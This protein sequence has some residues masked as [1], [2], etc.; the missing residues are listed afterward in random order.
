MAAGMEVATRA[1]A[2]LAA[3]AAAG[4]VDAV[5]AAAETAGAADAVDAVVAVAGTVAGTVAGEEAAAL[6]S[7]GC[8][9]TPLEVA[10]GPKSRSIDHL[11]EVE[12]GLI[13][14]RIG[15]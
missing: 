3:E 15:K 11:N 6:A 9:S 14:I 5:D 10:R 13:D 12:N 1:E 2:A 7:R 8:P 4:G